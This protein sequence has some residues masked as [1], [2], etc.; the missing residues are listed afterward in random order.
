MGDLRRRDETNPEKSL[1]HLSS[2]LARLHLRLAKCGRSLRADPGR[3]FP[4]RMTG[5]L[6]SSRLKLCCIDKAKLPPP[7]H[8]LLFLVELM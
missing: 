6:V 5:V 2:P 8:T 7:C 3:R 1:L 4:A